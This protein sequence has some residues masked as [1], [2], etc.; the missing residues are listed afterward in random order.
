MAMFGFYDAG[1]LRQIATN[2]F[3][4]WGYNFYRL[5]NQLRSDDQLVRSKCGWLLGLATEN[6]TR[7]EAEY[8][9]EF[10]PAPTR[11]KPYPEASSVTGAQTLER[12]AARLCAIGAR[13]QTEPVPE[14]DRMSQRFREEAPTLQAVM[15]FDEQMVGQCEMLRAGTEKQTGVWMLEHA[16]EIEGGLAAIEDTLHRRQAV[17]FGRAQPTFSA[18]GWPGTPQR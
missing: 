10:L 7:A 8:R 12:I 5:E 18:N 17:L 6:V 4:G 1:M 14:N 16:S 15:G 9:R 3:Y 11:L 2:L 13:M